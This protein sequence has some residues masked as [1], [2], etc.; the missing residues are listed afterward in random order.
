MS[1]VKLIGPTIGLLVY[2][3]S[4]VLGIVSLIV[5]GNIMLALTGVK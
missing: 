3:G 2:L 5:L 4:Y 1:P